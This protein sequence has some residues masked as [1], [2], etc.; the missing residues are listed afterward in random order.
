[1]SITQ[2]TTTGIAANA[3]TATQIAANAVTATQIAD[4]A[5]GSTEIADN[6]VTA[7]KIAA[8]AVTGTQIAA[9]AVGI[10]QIANFAV[11]SDKMGSGSVS[12]QHASNA[13]QS[14]IQIFLPPG[15]WFVEFYYTTHVF[16]LNSAMSMLIEGILVQTSTVVGDYQGTF[17]VP[18]FG[19]TYVTGNRSIT[20]SI[21]G[22]LADPN[23]SVQR[24]MVK[25]TRIY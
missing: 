15:T 11:T 24:C 9:N 20:C 18:M 10:T 4:G 17:Y 7:A 14:F 12:I 6:A 13:G 21:Q 3:V 16:G 19:G 8:E 1:M 2:V 25:A 22:A 5:V 23:P